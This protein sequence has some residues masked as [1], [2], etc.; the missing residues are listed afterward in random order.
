MRSS[1]GATAA[2]LLLLAC[3]AGHAAAEHP[4]AFQIVGA[5]THIRLTSGNN[6]VDV[7]LGKMYE[8]DANGVPVPGHAL[9]ALASLHP[10]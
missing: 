6:S 9:P 4:A 3:T 5:S 10:T 8:V 2:V 1:S 7:R